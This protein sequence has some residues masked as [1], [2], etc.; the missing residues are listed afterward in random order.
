MQGR[1]GEFD[2]I[3]WYAR[4]F[5]SSINKQKLTCN[6]S[7][8]ELIFQQLYALNKDLAQTRK[9]YNVDTAWN[10]KRGGVKN[11]TPQAKWNTKVS[12]KLKKYKKINDKFNSKLKKKTAKKNYLNNCVEE[13]AYN[14]PV[15]KD[16][17]E[18]FVEELERE[19]RSYKPTFPRKNQLK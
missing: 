13:Q 3:E 9:Q 2:V 4:M 8:I 14:I 11:P 5:Q 6:S 10:P 15:Y 18:D 12:N 7:S 16:S 19:K 1:Q 17:K